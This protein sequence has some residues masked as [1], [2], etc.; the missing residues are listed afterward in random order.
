MKVHAYLNFA[1]NAEEVFEYYKSVFGGEFT[2]VV[3]FKDMPM[4]GSSIPDA[5]QDKIMH[6][7]LQ[8]DEDFI[9][10]ASDALG[11]MGQTI[12][13][14]N[15]VYLSLHPNSKDEADRLFNALSAGGDVE[16]QIADQPW[17][18]YWGSLKDKFGTLWMVNFNQQAQG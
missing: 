12:T 6:I 16:M 17:G 15:N 5:D 10:M 13:Q 14:G 8:V 1:G 4:E 3:R 7:G 18:D 9:L 2:S 11:S